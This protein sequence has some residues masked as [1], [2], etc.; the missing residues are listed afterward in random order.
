[1]DYDRRKVYVN[2]LIFYLSKLE[3]KGKK[4]QSK[5]KETIKIRVEINKIINR[6][7][8][9]KINENKRSQEA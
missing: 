5:Q 2:D 6:K 3:N 8:T 9:E 1:M 7:T 4:S